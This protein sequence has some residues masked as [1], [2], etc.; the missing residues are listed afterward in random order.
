MYKPDS[1]DEQLA[2][3]LGQD[4]RITSDELAKKMKISSATVRRRLKRLLDNDLLRI[5]GVIDYDKFGFPLAVILTLNVSP[6]KL[7]SAIKQL[8]SKQEIRWISTTIGRYDIIARGRFRSNEHLSEFI[9]KDLCK[10]DG[11]RETETYVC[12][13]MKEGRY[14]PF[15]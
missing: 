14:V 13:N 4:A 3:L 8:S 7:E 2:K 6:D 5:V 10:I 1:T 9:R 12:L 15:T 11:L